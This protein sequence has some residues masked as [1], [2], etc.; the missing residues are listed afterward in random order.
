MWRGKV[1]RLRHTVTAANLGDEG[2][3]V[4]DHKLSAPLHRTVNLDAFPAQHLRRDLDHRDRKEGKNVNIPFP[5]YRK[6]VR[7]SPQTLTMM[8]FSSMSSP[9]VPLA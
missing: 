3:G 9:G 8:F 7:A 2:T 6:D 5:R 1:H 4:A